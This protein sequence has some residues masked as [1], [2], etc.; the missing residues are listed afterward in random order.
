MFIF[1]MK[2]AVNKLPPLRLMV[3]MLMSEIEFLYFRVIRYW[4][5]YILF[6]KQYTFKLQTDNKPAVFTSNTV[7]TAHNYLGNV[8]AATRALARRCF[9]SIHSCLIN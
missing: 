1:H 7:H 2:A 6:K 8:P 4:N 9:Y 5:T 3:A